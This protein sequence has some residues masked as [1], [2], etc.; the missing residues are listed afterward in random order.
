MTLVTGFCRVPSSSLQLGFRERHPLRLAPVSARRDRVAK[1]D[2]SMNIVKEGALRVVS[3]LP[4]ILPMMDSLSYGRFLFQKIP[5]LA[6][7]FMKPLQP[8]V[9][10][11]QAFPMIS[12][13]AFLGLFLF[14]VR[15]RKVP[16]FIRFNTMQALLLEILL[17][18][19]QILTSGNMGGLIPFVFTEFVSNMTFYAIAAIVGYSCISNLRG[20]L[21][22][23]IPVISTAVFQQIGG[24]AGFDD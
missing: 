7:I 20:E 17:I 24:G 22:C 18:F 15:N 8:F 16:R 3:C 5:L 2:I 23:K 21:P 10:L 4:Y 11:A 14:V 13:V 6:F 9:E 19:P 1:Q 12:F